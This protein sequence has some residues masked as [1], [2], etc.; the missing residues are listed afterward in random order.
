MAENKEK[1]FT[2]AI[3]RLGKERKKI[4]KLKLEHLCECK[5][6]ENPPIWDILLKGPK[7]SP[8]EKGKFQ[9][10]LIFSASY[11]MKAP[12][13][14]FKTKIYHP[15]VETNSGKLC[16]LIL[17]KDWAPTLNVQYVL[18]TLI[19]L[20]AKPTPDNPVEMD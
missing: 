16:H 15:S 14:V 17:E 11:P 1:D 9:A 10:Q 12:E 13:V 7:D 8:Y 20:L 2:K 3:K 19:E 4:D 6:Q 18:E 5:A